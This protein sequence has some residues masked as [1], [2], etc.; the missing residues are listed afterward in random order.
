MSAA[1]RR[2]LKCRERERAGFAGSYGPI[3]SGSVERAACEQNPTACQAPLDRVHSL[4]VLGVDDRHGLRPAVDP[5]ALG[6]AGHTEDSMHQLFG[7]T[8]PCLI[9]QRFEISG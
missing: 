9:A 2:A 5:P 7:P 1:S 3:D 4:S 6:L 8:D